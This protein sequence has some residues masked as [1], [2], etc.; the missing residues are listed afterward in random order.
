MNGRNRLSSS[1]TADNC[2]ANCSNPG[3]VP[4]DSKEKKELQQIT[5]KNRFAL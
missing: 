4:L 1:N 3:E 2:S 5:D